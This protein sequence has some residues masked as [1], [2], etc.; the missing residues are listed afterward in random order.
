MDKYPP[1]SKK[2]IEIIK[3]KACSELIILV[4]IPGSGKSLFNRMLSTINRQQSD[5]KK[6]KKKV[7]EWR[8]ANQDIL[9]K[10][11][12]GIRSEKMDAR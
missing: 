11:K 2:Q 10:R 12:C 8:C 9:G 7:M 3:G 6:S 1:L 5:D 4:G